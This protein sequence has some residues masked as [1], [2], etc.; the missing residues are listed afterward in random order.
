MVVIHGEEDISD[1]YPLGLPS[2]ELRVI[3][4]IKGSK[5]KN[6]KNKT[7][8]HE[9]YFMVYTSLHQRQSGLRDASTHTLNISDFIG[10][11]LSCAC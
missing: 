7:N 3:S 8:S 11:Y 4:D 2:A 9:E 1:H 10:P 5:K 6:K